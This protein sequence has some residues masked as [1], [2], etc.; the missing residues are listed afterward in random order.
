M[1][2]I[3]EKQG[4]LDVE[5]LKFHKKNR[6]T[7]RILGGILSSYDLYAGGEIQTFGHHVW[8]KPVNGYHPKYQPMDMMLEMGPPIG[9]I[10]SIVFLNFKLFKK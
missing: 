5:C 3:E 2:F 7:K 8:K 1:G 10:Q 9:F 4:P 6:R